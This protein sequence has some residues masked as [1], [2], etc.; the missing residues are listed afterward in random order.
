MPVTVDTLWFVARDRNW[1]AQ[2]LSI[3]LSQ[4]TFE[5][6]PPFMYGDATTTLA[7]RARMRSSRAPMCSGA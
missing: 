5:I 1:F 2:V 4:G 6:R 7:P 3:R